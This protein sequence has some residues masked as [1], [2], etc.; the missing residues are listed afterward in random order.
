MDTLLSLNLEGVKRIFKAC[1]GKITL[2][3]SLRTPT[4]VGDLKRAL[5]QA[6]ARRVDYAT[7]TD[8]AHSEPP[9]LRPLPVHNAAVTLPLPLLDNIQVALSQAR[10]TSCAG[11]STSCWLRM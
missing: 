1:K 7:I 6:I 8:D 11:I 4:R 9:A 5:V 2:P 3:A 10:S